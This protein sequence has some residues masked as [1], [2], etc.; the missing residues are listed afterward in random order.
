MKYIDYVQLNPFQKIWYNLK[1]FFISPGFQ[2]RQDLL[3]MIGRFFKKLGIGIGKGVAGYFT[4]FVKGDWAT[5]LSYIIMGFGNMMKGQIIKG[6]LFLLTEVAFIAFM[7]FF[8]ANKIYNLG[9]FSGG[10]IG[11]NGEDYWADANGLRAT[12]PGHGPLQHV[13]ADDSMQLLL[14]G[15]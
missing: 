8:G 5:K 7:I 4:R 9:F 14:Y 11:F 15:Y 3:A 1:T 13:R 12:D 10:T 2:Y 6:I